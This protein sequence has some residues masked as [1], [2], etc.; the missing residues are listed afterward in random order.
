MLPSGTGQSAKVRI[1]ALGLAHTPMPIAR[2]ASTPDKV[3]AS[4]PAGTAGTSSNAAS[5][6]GAGSISATYG[7][8]DA[9]ADA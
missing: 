2:P 6:A 3:A 7:Y 5:D 1:A 8:S 9:A 4:A